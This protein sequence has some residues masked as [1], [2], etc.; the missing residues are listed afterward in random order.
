MRDRFFAGFVAALLVLAILS[1]ALSADERDQATQFTFSQPVRVPGR[2]LPAGT[3]WFELVDRNAD[4]QTVAIYSADRRRLITM[5]QA[6]NAGRVA[7]TAHTVITLTDPARA[8]AVPAV[9]SWFYPGETTGHQF[10]YSGAGDERVG[11][12]PQIIL[13]LGRNR[14]I[15]QRTGSQTAIGQ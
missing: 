14:L 4:L 7:P 12:E 13:E 10:V 3:Y 15:A 9:V 2:T 11:S 8:S 5:A 6:L 1:P